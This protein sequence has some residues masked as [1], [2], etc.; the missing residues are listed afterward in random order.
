MSLLRIRGLVVEYPG[1]VAVR[2]V[3]NV[4]LDV[5]AGE[6]VGLAGESGCGKSTL[7]LAAA[8]LLPRGTSVSADELSFGGHDM[9]TVTEPEMRGLR[10]R[11]LSL[12]FQGAM[13][14]FNPVMTIGDQIAE[15]IHT[16]DPAK[17]RQAIR[18]QVAELL[19]AVGVAPA[20]AGD[21]PHQLSGGM[22]QR[23]MIAMALACEP[24]LIIADEPTTA[25]DVM[26]QAQILD[27]IRRL[28]DELGLAML[29]ISHDLTVLAE[30]CDRV[31]VMYAGRIIEHGPN[32][33]ILGTA[34]APAH[35]Y[36]RRLLD[37][38]PRLEG[39]RASINGIPGSP[40]D[41]AHPPAGCRFHERCDVSVSI[42]VTDDPAP[43]PVAGSDAHEA[44]C[45]LLE[46]VSTVRR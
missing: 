30:L 36:T 43:R 33:E 39:G 34:G 17:P 18:T 26:T 2:A 27:L 45:H 46:P 23:S 41:L 37:C 42:C 24:E 21:Y 8:R 9:L 12:V 11:K 19:A 20:R 5:S 35:P 13:N 7:A 32:D 14:G 3:D 16:H 31:A 10:W 6:V 22:K 15:A 40:P 38:Y 29:I 4:D 44:A 25:L 28:A 1:D